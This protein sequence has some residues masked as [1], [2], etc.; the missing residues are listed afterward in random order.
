M[1]QRTYQEKITQKILKKPGRKLNHPT[2]NLRMM[3]KKRTLIMPGSRKVQRQ[4]A[5]KVK[6]KWKMMKQQIP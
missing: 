5:H 4:P 3:I 2:A 1:I 6:L